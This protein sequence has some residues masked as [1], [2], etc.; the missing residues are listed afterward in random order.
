MRCDEV[1]PLLPSFVEPELRQ[2]GSVDVHV[3]SCEACRSELEAYRSLLDALA[4]LRD[5]GEDA[6]EASVRHAI[7]LIPQPGLGTRVAGSI[8][9]HRRLYATLAA[10]IGGAAFGATALAIAIRRRSAQRVAL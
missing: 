4:E 1:R 7:E 8:V 2:A 3:A 10:S 6:S 9:A 5:V